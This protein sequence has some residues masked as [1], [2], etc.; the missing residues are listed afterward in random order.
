MDTKFSARPQILGTLYQV[1]RYPLYLALKNSNKADYAVFIERYDDIEIGDESDRNTAIQVKHVSTNLTNRSSHLWKTLRVWSEHY[2]SGLVK[3]PG[4]ILTLVTTTESPTGS[5]AAFLRAD[6]RNTDQAIRLLK[7]ELISVPASLQTE[8]E[9]FGALDDPAQRKLVE[10]MWVVDGAAPIE[11][12]PGKIKEQCIGVLSSNLDELYERL[13]GW[14]VGQVITHMHSGS[15]IPIMAQSV[16][17]T[18]ANIND[19]LRERQ[20]ADPFLDAPLPEEYHWDDRTFVRQLHLVNFPVQLLLRAKQD[21]YRAKNLRKYLVDELYLSELTSYDQ[22]LVEQWELRFYA[23]IDEGSK[24]KTDESELQKLGRDICNSVL[25][26][27]QVPVERRLPDSTEYVTRGSYHILAD[28]E[29][30]LRV[31]W[32][33]QFRERLKPTE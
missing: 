13:E 2:K 21:Y 28:D 14:W 9:A 20:L 11:D 31:G 29:R 27:V 24:E 12:I 22:R 1:L 16:R 7:D 3:L 6:G 4:S 17:T 26:E 25:K 10:A 8:F 15:T 32:H 18:I 23:A 19:S 33:P 5:I 30:N